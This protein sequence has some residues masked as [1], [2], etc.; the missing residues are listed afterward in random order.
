[1]PDDDITPERI[2]ELLR[3][4]PLLGDPGSNTE[5]TWHG[6]DQ[7][8]DSG[9]I[10]APHPVYPEAVAEFFRLAGQSWWCDLAY[11][12]MRAGKM[13]HS[14]RVIAEASL[15][16]IRTMLTFCVRGERFCD[17][18]WDAM[19]RDGRIAALLRRLEDLRR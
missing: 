13:V 7:D 11:D 8:P 4:L 9:V 14:D 16:Q 12:P 1:M 18:H 15:P 2:D 6:L 10:Q 17:G 19:I 5:P 3:F